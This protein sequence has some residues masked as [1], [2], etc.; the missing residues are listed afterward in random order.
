[1]FRV[2]AARSLHR[3]GPRAH[4]ENLA[5]QF[6]RHA[7]RDEAHDLRI[8]A[9]ALGSIDSHTTGSRELAAPK[10]HRSQAQKGSGKLDGSAAWRTTRAARREDR[11]V[12]VRSLRPLLSVEL[13]GRSQPTTR[14]RG[15]SKPRG[16]PGRREPDRD[17]AGTP[18][19]SPGRQAPF[20]DLSCG[21][22]NSFAYR[23]SDT[24]AN[25]HEGTQRAR[26]SDRHV[27]R[28]RLDSRIRARAE[29]RS[30]R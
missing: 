10:K 6:Q 8:R 4:R 29:H 19:R 14:E 15:H 7:H 13:P 27:A 23:C 28:S 25:E 20:P 30:A 16:H 21:W 18:T 3:A 22:A 9:R 26:I 2:P 1:M 24:R 12:S 17:V 11:T 5:R